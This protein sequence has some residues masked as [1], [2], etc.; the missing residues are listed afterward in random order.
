MFDKFLKGFYGTLDVSVDY[1]TKGMDDRSP[2][3]M[4]WSIRQ[5]VF[6]YVRGPAKEAA[7]HRWARSA[8][9]R[10]CPPTSSIGYRGTHKIPGSTV[11]FIYQV[12]QPPYACARALARIHGAVRRHQGGIGSATPSSAVEQTWGK[13]KFGT[14]YTPY[15]NST[16]R[17][18]PFSGMLGDYAVIMGNTGGDNRVEFGT[19]SIIRSGTNRPIGGF[20]L[21]RLL[22]PGQNRTPDNSSIGGL[23][24]LQRRQCAGQRQPAAHCDDGGFDDAYS[25]DLKFEVGVVWTAAYELHKHVNRNSDG[26]GSNGPYYGYLLKS[27]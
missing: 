23:S 10:S 9:C 17:L 6:G 18:N 7:H 4:R 5:P 16:D 26:I 27:R 19:R 24:R 2:T 11:D 12:V 1:I 14:M 22:S 13:L 8:G 3:A 20:Q 25:V 15:K 21:R